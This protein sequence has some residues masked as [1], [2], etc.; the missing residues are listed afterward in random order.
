MGADCEVVL[1]SGATCGIVA[2][3][4]CSVCEVALCDSHRHWEGASYLCRTCATTTLLVDTSCAD[5]TQRAR[6]RCTQCHEPKC[7]NHMVMRMVATQTGRS[8]GGRVE[9]ATRSVADG[10]CRP[11]LARRLVE[12]RE[13]VAS[14][15]ESKQLLAALHRGGVDPRLVGEAMTRLWT[16]GEVPAPTHDLLAVHVEIGYRGGLEEVKAWREES[17]IP[18]WLAAGA[19]SIERFRGTSTGSSDEPDSQRSL[20]FV[21]A[22]AWIASDGTVWQD[23]LATWGRLPNT[24][25]FDPANHEPHCFAVTRGCELGV[26]R[27]S[28]ILRRMRNNYSDRW[29]ALNNAIRVRQARISVGAAVRK[30]LA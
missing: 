15:S 22:D 6:H 12:T 17:R 10:V 1:G 16:A 28:P 26:L 20:G 5:C 30:L 18:A 24:S 29:P 14:A 9:S 3:A 21:P 4:R 27:A 23:A 11:C 2:T 8:V 13:Q 7:D 19:T 25:A